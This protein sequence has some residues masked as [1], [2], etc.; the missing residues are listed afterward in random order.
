MVA[1]MGFGEGHVEYALGGEVEI[2]RANRQPCP[3][4][5]HPTGDCT[6]KDHGDVTVTGPGAFVSMDA[7]EVF[8]VQENV[9]EERA[10]SPFT[11]TRVLVAAK[12]AAISRERAAELGL[13]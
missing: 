3:V 12:G 2:V 6:G 11:T 4:C 9:Y 10:I 1:H 13:L 7:E 8:I 5:N